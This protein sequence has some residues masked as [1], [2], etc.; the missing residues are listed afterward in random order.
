MWERESERESEREIE[1]KRE[2]SGMGHFTGMEHLDV[3]KGA[4]AEEEDILL[5][6]CIEKYG[7]GK[8]RQIP[9]SAGRV[10]LLCKLGSL[11]YTLIA[12]G[13]GTWVYSAVVRNHAFEV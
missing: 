5:R 13:S 12:G 2:S 6:K 10:Q 8:W 1:R 4:W 3:R 7:E 11:Q 9:M